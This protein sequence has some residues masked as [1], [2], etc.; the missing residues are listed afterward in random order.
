MIERSLT[1]TRPHDRSAVHHTMA[2]G[3]F[4]ELFTVLQA[5]SVGGLPGFLSSR[6]RMR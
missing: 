3:H 2:R 4:G 5:A 6:R 1:G